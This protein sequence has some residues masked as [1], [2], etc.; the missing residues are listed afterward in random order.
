MKSNGHWTNDHGSEY[1]EHGP[2]YES[3]GGWAG[4]K[5]EDFSVMSHD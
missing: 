2:Y 3:Q 5:I 4:A 1:Y